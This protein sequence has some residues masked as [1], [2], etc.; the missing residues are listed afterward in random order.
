MNQIV[1]NVEV[2]D[3]QQMVV[4]NNLIFA[5]VREGAIIPSKNREDMGYD[6]YANFQEDMMIIPSHTTVMIP[7]GIASAMSEHYGVIL[8]ERG[9][10]GTKG[11]AQRSGVIEGSYRGEWFVPITNTTDSILIISKLSKEESLAKIYKNP[12]NR[13]KG[14]IVYPYTKAITQAVVIPVPVMTVHEISYEELLE[15]PSKR[16]TGALGSSN[17]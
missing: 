10:T 2:L 12:L 16:G 11:I 4:G 3:M 5:K 15:I 9:S 13:G 7:T 8:K 6:V 17:K 14:V 1:K